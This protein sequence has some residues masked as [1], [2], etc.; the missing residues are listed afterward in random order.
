MLQRTHVVGDM[1]VPI[2]SW[3]GVPFH[4][5]SSALGSSDGCWRARV[6]WGSP[7]HP[8]SSTKRQRLSAGPGRRPAP[9]TH[10]RVKLPLT[11][12]HTAGHLQLVAP[13]HVGDG[14]E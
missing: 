2:L 9:R 3:E 10:D 1:M 7:G 11:T 14:G 13:D 6:T 4:A 5:R 12:R 8:A